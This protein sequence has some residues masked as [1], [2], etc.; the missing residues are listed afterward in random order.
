VK[1]MGSAAVGL[2]IALAGLVWL[3]ALMERFG[4]I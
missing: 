4:L 2:V 1:D 3:A